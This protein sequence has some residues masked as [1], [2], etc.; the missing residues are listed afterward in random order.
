[1]FSTKIV[2]QRN[3][4]IALLIA[5]IF[6]A[7]FSALSAAM[8]TMSSGNAVVASNLHRVNE[9]RSSS[10]SGLET[11]RY[12]LAQVEIPWNT[13]QNQWFTVLKNQVTS[14]GFMPS[15]FNN[16]EDEYGYL[17]IGADSPV[18]LSADGGKTF[19]AQL[20]DVS[21]RVVLQ[22][23]G[24]AG[25]ISRR[26]QGRFNYGEKP[27]PYSVFDFGVATKGPLS[28]QGNILLAGV[29]ISVESD[30]YIESLDINK[31]LEII[32][33]SQIAGDVKIV[34]DDAYVVL[35]GGKAGI[36]GETGAAAIENHVTV[37]APQTLF[38]IP[39]TS[40]FEPYATGV[41]INSGNIGSYNNNAA[42]ENVRIA[43]NTN[44]SF[45]GN[46][47][48]KGV[49]FIEQPNTV[50]FTGNAAITG[51]IVGDG[52]Y[53][54]NSGTNKL[55]FQ[56]TVSSTAVNATNASGEYLLAGE[57]FDGIRSDTGTFIMAPGFA[58]SMGGNFGTLNGCI[59]A[60]GVN[61]YGNAGGIIG[62]SVLNYSDQPMTLSGNSDLY[63]NRTGNTGVPNGF[64]TL[65][66]IEVRYDP[67]AYDEV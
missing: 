31:A 57:Q 23:T 34:N 63:F 1:M 17:L 45:G 6:V 65:N 16:T 39:N 51:V 18:V 52:D 35:Q 32:G 21:D 43:A 3:K 46:C 48:I 14:S 33:N 47:T 50:T 36:G 2:S 7:I 67:G 11:M 40:H 19:S 4:G 24:N 60:N 28:L 29:N 13:P 37:G 9:A 5:L 8:F 27:E 58:V 44:P 25:N 22:V 12:Y 41:T 10:E 66:N 26:I 49:M 54:D 15:N 38:P 59:A 64:E 20:S 62:G 30:V 61:F 53:N 56:G 55:D 42:L